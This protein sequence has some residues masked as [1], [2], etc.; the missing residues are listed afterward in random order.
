[1]ELEDG[2]SFKAILNTK[3]RKSGK[4]HSVELLAVFYNNKMY[5]S[6]RNSNSDWLKNAIA[7][8]DVKI[9]FEDNMFVGQAELVTDKRLAKKISSLKYDD[10]RSEE[11]RIVLQVTLRE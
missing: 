3:G 2:Q 11:S 8:P 4:P 6:R 5:F 7:N 1:M 10:K 9:E